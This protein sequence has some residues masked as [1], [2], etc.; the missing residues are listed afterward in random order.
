ML[1]TSLMGMAVANSASTGTPSITNK[2]CPPPGDDVAQRINICEMPLGAL[3][4]VTCTPATLPARACETFPEPES[5]DE[6]IILTEP[7]KDLR[8][9]V[10][11]D[12]V[13][14]TS[15]KDMPAAILIL[16]N[17]LSLL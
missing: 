11:P 12:E 15:L 8:C 17:P 6:L 14:T 4:S 13:T 16:L 1:S 2:G 9:L 3:P 10:S 7:A 5:S